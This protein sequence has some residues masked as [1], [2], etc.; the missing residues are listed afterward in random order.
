MKKLKR[1]GVSIH[2]GMQGYIEMA[3]NV[4]PL[5]QCGIASLAQFPIAAPKGT[6]PLPIPPRYDKRPFRVILDKNDHL[7]RHVRNKHRNT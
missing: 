2:N 7:S 1:T 6:P 4:P 5:G 3:R